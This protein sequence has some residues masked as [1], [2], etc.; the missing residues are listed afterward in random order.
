[1]KDAGLRQ[2]ERES[3]VRAAVKKE[4]AV[5]VAVAVAEVASCREVCTR[6]QALGTLESVG[7]GSE[8]KRGSCYYN[9]FKQGVR[10]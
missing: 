10:E 2:G 7:L 5:A 6:K 9:R 1:V 8:T 4:M 3:C